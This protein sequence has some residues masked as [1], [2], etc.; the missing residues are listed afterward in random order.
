MGA[1]GGEP[2]RAADSAG[3]A[4]VLLA[5]GLCWAAAAALS[6]VLS[7]VLLVTRA[8]GPAEVSEEL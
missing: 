2:W 7:V 1:E 6:G 3:S 8:R 5:A 4:L